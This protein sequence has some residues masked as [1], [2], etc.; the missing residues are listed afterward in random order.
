MKPLIIIAHYGL[1]RKITEAECK[2]AIKTAEYESII[3]I[4]FEACSA[5]LEELYDLPFDNIALAQQRN[6]LQKVSPKL[7]ENPNAHIAYFGLA[8]IP[9]SFH[10]GYLLGNT[11][12]F[13]IFQYHHTKK[14]WLDNTE[15]PLQEYDFKIEPVV[16]PQEVQNGKGNV[17]IRIGTSY[18][19]DR[20]STLELVDNPANEFDIVLKQPDVDALYNQECINEVVESFQSVLNAY[21]NKLSDREQIHLFIASSAG[22]PF[23]LGTRIN[24]N[25]YPYIQT[26]QF[27]RDQQ[28][29]YREAVLIS[30]E[31]NNQAT[32]S[33][34]DRNTAAAIREEWNSLIN[35]KIKPF[36]RTITGK[37][38]QDWLH[39]LCET[40]DDY[41]AVCK[42]L[43]IPWK[44]VINIGQTSLKD[45]TVDIM[46]VNVQGGF[47]YIERTNTWQLDDGF[48]S[49]LKKRLD[50]NK[51]TDLSQA[52]RLFFFHEALHYANDGHRLT[53]EIADG[54]GQ[55]PKVIEDADYQA[56]V[57]ALLTEYRYCQTY[58]SSKIK[59]GV[60]SFF[61]NAI[62]TAVETM[63]SFIDNG[64]DLDDLQIR[65]LNR[66]LNW[67]WQWVRI[68]A[69]EGK[70][71]LEDVVC[72][73]L[74]KPV[75]EL[76]GAPMTLRA[77]RTFYRLKVRDIS[78]IQLAAFYKNKVYRFAPNLIGN[79]VD[80][81]RQL[82]GEKIK[83][84][85]K[86]FHNNIV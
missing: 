15:P 26:Y 13:S 17:V 52:A 35:D 23:A 74:N 31:S 8:P 5:K 69:I 82:N 45:D 32:I 51:L 80:G 54:I 85:L 66:F 77:H 44:E 65:S 76:A 70:G 48:L 14:V 60:K 64:S 47:E 86:S 78:N 84:G 4:D 53:R 58:E 1:D 55:F 72:I 18:L 25:V 68:E 57:W 50:K 21:S 61:C 73:L 62:D 10:F 36:I 49:G 71:K 40:E 79:I 56:D 41:T 33:D 42:Y 29:R 81:F 22:L 16:L 37:P 11:H 28:P 75:I 43:K 83:Q 46:T 7:E 6:F 34:D 12:S 9:I 38:S 30:K 19:I 24:P 67:Y 2:A 3:F 63:W 39:V 20:N 59:D 27:S